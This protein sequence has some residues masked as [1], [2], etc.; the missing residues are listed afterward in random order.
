MRRERDPQ[1]TVWTSVKCPGSA[2]GAAGG[3]GFWLLSGLRRGPFRSQMKRVGRL[4][5][6]RHVLFVLE[7]RGVDAVSQ[8]S[9]V[10]PV[11][12]DVTKVGAAVAAGH[13]YPLHAEA[14]V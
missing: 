9:R 13:F 6:L 14:V 11:V 5:G 4:A 12:K 1:G 3:A 8:P 2:A 7:R 10:R